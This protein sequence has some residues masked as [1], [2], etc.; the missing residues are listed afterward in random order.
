MTKG[1]YIFAVNHNINRT[2]AGLEHDRRSID[3]FDWKSAGDGY[4][5]TLFQTSKVE[6]GQGNVRISVAGIRNRPA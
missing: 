2:V 6:F 5:L 1:I 4:K 3:L